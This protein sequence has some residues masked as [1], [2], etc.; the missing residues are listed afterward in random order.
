MEEHDED[1]D[2]ES[3]KI[4]AKKDW[5]EE[6]ISVSKMSNGLDF[7]AFLDCCFELVDIWTPGVTPEVSLT[8]TIIERLAC[9]PN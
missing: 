3:A 2:F 1:W 7:K 9:I 5:E 4:A 6:D 8:L